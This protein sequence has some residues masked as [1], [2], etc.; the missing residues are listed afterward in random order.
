MNLFNPHN[1]SAPPT[2]LHE[3]QTRDEGAAL[4]VANL[5]VIDGVGFE[6]IE[7][8]LLAKSVTLLEEGVFR[9]GSGEVPLDGP[10]VRGHLLGT[11]E[12]EGGGGRG[13]L[14]L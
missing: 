5:T 10:L 8:A 3:E 9:K 13:D 7:Q 4:T 14:M 2:H 12:W 1:S 6:H 11:E